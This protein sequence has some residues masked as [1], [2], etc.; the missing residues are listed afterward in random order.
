VRTV[1]G[2][3]TV[4]WRHAK[5]DQATLEWFAAESTNAYAS[6]TVPLSA[7]P[8]HGFIVTGAGVFRVSLRQPFA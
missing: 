5:L 6:T 1:G 4:T 8:P 7:H 3:T 2:Q